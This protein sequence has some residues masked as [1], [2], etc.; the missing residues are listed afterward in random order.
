MPNLFTSAGALPRSHI[1]LSYLPNSGNASPA[2]QPWTTARRLVC[3]AGQGCPQ[4]W[5]KSAEPISNQCTC[6]PSFLPNFSWN[7]RVHTTHPKLPL[8]LGKLPKWCSVQ[9]VSALRQAVSYVGKLP[10]LG[11]TPWVDPRMPAL[12]TAWCPGAP[13]K[14]GGLSAWLSPEIVTLWVPICLPSSYLY[15]PTGLSC[16]SIYMSIF[17]IYICRLE[18]STKTTYRRTGVTFHLSVLYVIIC[19]LYVLGGGLHVWTLWGD[20]KPIRA[21]WSYLILLGIHNDSGKWM[22][23]TQKGRVLCIFSLHSNLST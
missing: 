18:E 8:W 11:G 9:R 13:C 7:R 4:S 15:L 20:A 14:G 5:K 22:K 16:L 1:L 21:I 10:V 2:R 17:T 12:Q 6:W 19:D 3:K 23:T